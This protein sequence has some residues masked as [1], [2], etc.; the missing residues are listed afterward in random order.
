VA[1]LATSRGTSILLYD[2]E[3]KRPAVKYY[4]LDRRNSAIEDIGE[5]LKLPV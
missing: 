5:F 1:S 3:I 4:Q 2:D